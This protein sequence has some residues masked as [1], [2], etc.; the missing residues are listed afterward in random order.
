MRNI[1]PD[2][3]LQ[4]SPFPLY[5]W[6]ALLPVPRPDSILFVFFLSINL[7]PFH[8]FAYERYRKPAVNRFS[9]SCGIIRQNQSLTCFAGY[10]I[11]RKTTGFF[12]R[13]LWLSVAYS[14]FIFLIRRSSDSANLISS[15]AVRF[16]DPHTSHGS[17]LSLAASTAPWDWVYS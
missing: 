8:L 10:F 16:A 11:I 13:S 9:A 12:F 2:K 14:I 6:A 3:G 5:P 15:S 4:S 1:L 7:P 17:I